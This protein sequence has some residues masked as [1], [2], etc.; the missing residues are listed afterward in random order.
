LTSTIEGLPCHV[1]GG[2]Q[3]VMGSVVA[4]LGCYTL[5]M[6]MMMMMMMTTMWTKTRPC[7]HT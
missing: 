5:C 3:L 7:V 4:G 1:G 2:G 6:M